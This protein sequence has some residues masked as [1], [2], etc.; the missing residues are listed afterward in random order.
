MSNFSPAQTLAIETLDKNLVVKAGAG[1]GKTRVLVE[2][3]VRIMETGAA[4]LDGIVAITFT[5]KAAREMKE[6]IRVRVRVLMEENKG[7]EHWQKWYGIARK[8]DTACISTIH[9]LCSRILREHPAEAGIDP[10]FALLD[11]IDARC[12]LDESWHGILDQAAAKDAV[13]LKNVLAVYS[14]AQLR[15]DFRSLFETVA[16]GGLID[17]A[18]EKTLWPEGCAPRKLNVAALRDAYLEVFSLIHMNGRTSQTLTALKAIQENWGGID[19]QISLIETNPEI[20]DELELP[21]KTM[22]SSGELGDAIKMW[23]NAADTLRGA[24]LDSQICRIAP[25]I[26]ELFK[27]VQDSYEK[28]K[29]MRRVLTYD[30]LENKT[31]QLLRS[32]PEIC[33]GYNRRIRFVMVD[34][35]QDINERQRKIIYML[36]GGHADELRRRALFVVGDIKQSIYRFRGADNRVFVRVEQDICRNGGKMVELS[37]NYRSHRNL[38]EAFNGFFSELMPVSVCEGEDIAGF[39]AIEYQY[40]KGN[41]GEE[42]EEQLEMWVLNGDVLSGAEARDK[43]AE[44]I[45]GKIRDLVESGDSS[46]RYGDIAILLRAFTNIASY[47]AALAKAGIPYYVAGGRGFAGRQEIQDVLGLLRFLCNSGNETAL[48]G[49]L[50]SPL[51][52]LSDDLLLRL[53]QYGGEGGIWSGLASAASVEG[54]TPEEIVIAQQ[55]RDVLQSWLEKRDFLSPAHL[56]K[57][58]FAVTGFDLFQMTQ[59]MGIRRYANLQKLLH[60]AQSYSETETGDLAAFIQYADLRL[61]EEGEAEIDSE[62]GNTVRIMTI[63]KSKGLEFPVVIVPDLQRKFLSRSQ[64][65]VFV[66]GSGL[67]MKVPDS[68]G[69]LRESGQYRRIARQDR[70]LE[71]AELKRVLYVAMTRAQQRIILSAVAKSPKSAKS[72]QTSS[73]W[74]D[75]ARVMLGLPGEIEDWPAEKQLGSACMKISRGAVAEK[76]GVCGISLPKV[77]KPAASAGELSPAVRRNIAPIQT[78]ASRPLIL[79]P[80]YLAEY[81][82]CPRSYYFARI[83]HIPEPPGMFSGKTS[84]ANDPSEVLSRWIGT[85]F[86]RFLELLDGDIAWQVTFEKAIQDTIAPPLRKE[87]ETLLCPLIEKYMGSS[88]HEKTCSAV[89]DRREW[90]FQYKL[91]AEKNGLPDVWMSGQVDRVL[92]YITGDIGIVDYKTDRVTPGELEKK[93]ARYRLQLAGYALAAGAVFG[94]SIGDAQLYFARTGETADIDVSDRGLLDSRQELQG[95]AE[96]IR[97]NRNETDYPCRL[98]SCIYCRYKQICLQS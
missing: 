17:S 22:R 84:S 7:T 66:R 80:A 91:L 36:A 95:I 35:C 40:L 87:A 81:A 70:A 59:L 93:T 43:E 19:A 5:R 28:A 79:S 26:C 65:G 94:R 29:Q 98:A 73:G 2:R 97:K 6:R 71:R 3:F 23:K 18:L 76:G 51:F 48:F 15:Q 57:E 12:L 55:I 21:W 46:V 68:Q 54:L 4:G 39:D 9:A 52:Q 67:G 33:S 45:S 13:W 8:M 92:F 38:I 96:F 83:A 89:E 85:A 16:A 11:D 34:E 75:W 10:D 27:L 1:A 86:H 25:H 53:R 30:D 77:E 56:L 61:H 50:R 74:L 24:M 88:L 78:G 60:L 32:H 20:L 62:L 64:L 14:P 41:Q 63:H 49:V 31:E 58:I 42:G 90:A 69:K 72:M 37:E 44:M 82:T 47:E